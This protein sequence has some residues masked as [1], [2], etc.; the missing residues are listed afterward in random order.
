MEEAPVFTLRN[1]GLIPDLLV[2]NKLLA[3]AVPAIALI[4]NHFFPDPCLL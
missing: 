4:S 1:L 2:R 3:R